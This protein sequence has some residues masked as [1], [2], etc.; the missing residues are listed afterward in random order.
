MKIRTSSF[1]LK[2]SWLFILFVSFE[3]FGL[4]NPSWGGLGYSN[5]GWFGTLQLLTIMACFT[6]LFRIKRFNF[7]ELSSSLG[8]IMLCFQFLLVIVFFQTIFQY[9]IGLD[10]FISTLSNIV[11]LKYVLL[12]FLFIFLLKKENGLD[13]AIQMINVAAIF[14]SCVVI[15]VA[16]F[17][18][19]LEAIQLSVSNSSFRLFRI[20]LP[21]GSL[22]AFSFFYYLSAWNL[23]KKNS[24]ALLTI[25][26]SIAL[27]AQMHRTV[28][29]ATIIVVCLGLILMLENRVKSI[30]RTLTVMLFFACALWISL[31]SAGYELNYIYSLIDVG[32][33][34]NIESSG[35]RYLLPFNSLLYVIKNYL[36]FGV[37]LDWATIVDESAYRALS[38]YYATPT[39]D[40]GYNNVI[41]IFGLLGASVYAAMI[42]NVS[43]SLFSA[44][45]ASDGPLKL[46]LLAALLSWLNSLIMGVSSDAFLLQNRAVMFIF[47]LSVTHHIHVSSIT[48]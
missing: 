48:R 40:S 5:L 42:Y 25:I 38:V 36:I 23:Y 18:V 13:M 24:Y 12:Y 21:T 15:A 22:I 45:R 28:L 19:Q 26:C 17:G 37:G 35:V 30:L 43:R 14:S 34:D 47:I 10:D 33:G 29:L 44:L 1:L 31:Q 20:L 8:K 4:R 3:G 9:F 6:S 41:V 32:S 39:Y 11:K 2:L 7:F 27:L 46:I 16:L